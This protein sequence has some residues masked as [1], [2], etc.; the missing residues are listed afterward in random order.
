MVRKNLG[1]GRCI[2]S[3]HFEFQTEYLCSEVDA[4]FK[5]YQEFGIARSQPKLLRVVKAS[6]LRFGS[7]PRI[8]RSV[9]QNIDN[10][11][12]VLRI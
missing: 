3:I 8:F 7:I 4:R 12:C 5:S 6:K 9:N 1:N 2:T 11:G 10:K